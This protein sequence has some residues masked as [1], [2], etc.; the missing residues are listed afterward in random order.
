MSI[1]IWI[2]ITRILFSVRLR[3]AETLFGKQE[4]STKILLVIGGIGIAIGLLALP[5]IAERF[6]IPLDYFGFGQTWMTAG[7]LIWYTLLAAQEEILKFAGSFIRYLR[8]HLTR[9]DLI[10][11]SIFIALG[12]GFGENIIYLVRET[13]GISEAANLAVTRWF[14]SFM[15]HALFT[16][17]IW[18]VASRLTGFK[19][20]FGIIWWIIIGIILH[21]GYNLSL[22]YG[23][24]LGFTAYILGWYLLLSYLFWS[25]DRVYLD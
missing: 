20:I 18:W 2:I 5:G 15:G 8:Q 9:N 3:V 14:T 22:H 25:S 7:I 11:Y 13:Q 23:L 12:F 10:L 6:G 1:I 16:G 17:I 19:Q 21:A 4:S 24:I